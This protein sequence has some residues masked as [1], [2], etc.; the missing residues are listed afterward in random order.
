MKIP[1]LKVEDQRGNLIFLLHK[2]YTFFL[3]GLDHRLRSDF[4]MI[5]YSMNRIILD[6]HSWLAS[7]EF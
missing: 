6:L 4:P 5:N 7:N 2:Q 1:D 3:E